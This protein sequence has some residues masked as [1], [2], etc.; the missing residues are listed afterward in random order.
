MTCSR[1]KILSVLAAASCKQVQCCFLKAFM[2]FFA[3]DLEILFEHKFFLCDSLS[4]NTW[5]YTHKC[6]L[7]RGFQASVFT[8]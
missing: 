4:Q 6:L 1:S 7:A 2:G 3:A 5:K 8:I